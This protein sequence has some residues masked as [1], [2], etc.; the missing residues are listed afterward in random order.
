MNLVAVGQERFKILELDRQTKAYLMGTVENFPLA[1]PSFQSLEPQGER[2]RS[3]VE[4]YVQ[5]LIEAG[6]AQFDLHELPSDPVPLA[7]IAGSILQAT[8]A[9]KQEILSIPDA[10]ELVNHMTALYRREIA[11]LRPLLANR[12]VEPGTFSN[13]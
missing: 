5:R 3:L 1:F 11:L 6:A 9:Q 10:L 8:P 4:R 2:L 12:A 7:Y 13:N